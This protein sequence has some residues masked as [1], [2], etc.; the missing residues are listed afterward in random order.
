[1]KK[2]IQLLDQGFESSS[3]KTPEFKAFASQ[4][5]KDLNNQLKLVGAQ[6]V[7]YHV[8]HFD[9]SGFFKTQE[10]KLYYFSFGDV[11]GMKYN[12]TN[13]YSL[14]YRTAKHLKDW[15]GGGNQWITFNGLENKLGERMHLS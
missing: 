5:K 10:D 6:I 2:S 3:T 11:R 8:G 14:M 7:A 15:T 12:R 13:Q 9:V 4:F 1:M